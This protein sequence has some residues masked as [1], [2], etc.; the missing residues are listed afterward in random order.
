[1]ANDKTTIEQARVLYIQRRNVTD[2]ARQLEIT[3]ATVYRWIE[4]YGW[5][6]L[7]T[8]GS[9]K[10]V[11][12]QR[13]ATLVTKGSK[14]T[15][16]LQEIE[17]LAGILERLEK[18]EKQ[19][20]NRQVAAVAKGETEKRPRKTAPKTKNNFTGLDVNLLLEQFQ[21]SQY[22]YQFELY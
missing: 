14:T 12:E 1:M 22:D 20:Q 18:L 3:R 11:T 15:G 16:E 8:E 6:R 7:R 21:A 4:Q 9:P 13:L 2:I 17:L 10:E 19:E 5:D